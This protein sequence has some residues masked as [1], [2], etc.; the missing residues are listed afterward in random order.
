MRAAHQIYRVAYFNAPSLSIYMN[1]AVDVHRK[2]KRNANF[3]GGK[4]EERYE[5]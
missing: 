1:T 2:N 5:G 3:D 4:K